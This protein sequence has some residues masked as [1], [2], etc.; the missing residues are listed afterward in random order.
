[1]SIFSL[2]DLEDRR[3]EY[4]EALGQT[5]ALFTKNIISERMAVQNQRASKRVYKLE[6]KD[7]IELLQNHTKKLN[8]KLTEITIATG[9]GKQNQLVSPELRENVIEAKLWNST[10][11]SS[12][13]VKTLTIVR[14]LC[15]RLL[16]LER[17]SETNSLEY[18]KTK[19]QLEFFQNTKED[20]FIARIQGGSDIRARIVFDD[21][22]IEIVQVTAGGLFLTGNFK[23]E[24]TKQD[25]SRTSVYDRIEPVPL[26]S[27][28]MAKL[29]KLS[30]TIKAKDQIET[31]K[32]AFIDADN[33]RKFSLRIESMSPAHLIK[34][35]LIPAEERKKF[36]NDNFLYTGK[37]KPDVTL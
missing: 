23:L 19:Q 25:V 32:K 7:E 20:T 5:L 37:L 3:T 1:M 31:E 9:A 4:R 17:N 34:V 26:V 27:M 35:Q 10:S 30:D 15:S 33:D 21:N 24:S 36:V 13:K 16:V 2:T 22:R 12:R 11:V 18:A 8:A 6:S 29:Y 28:P 14:G